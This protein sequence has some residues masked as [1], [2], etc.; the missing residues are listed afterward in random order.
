MEL[1]LPE[2]PKRNVKGQFIKGT[3]PHNKGK[4][5]VFKSEES[6]QKSLNGLARNG[7]KNLPQ[8]NKIK[9]VAI[10][11]GKPRFFN[12][13]SEAQLI[14]GIAHQSIRHCCNN[15]RKSAGGYKWFNEADICKWSKL[16]S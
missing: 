16:I 13:A 4:T 12:S 6:K 15:K 5:N 8:Q 2:P 11:D 14:T 9:I 1:R 3:P 10:K 7:N